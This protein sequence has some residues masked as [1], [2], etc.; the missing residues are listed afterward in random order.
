MTAE[1]HLVVGDIADPY[2]SAIA[3]GVMAP[4]ERAP[5]PTRCSPR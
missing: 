5:T 3:A 4:A 1:D 2:F